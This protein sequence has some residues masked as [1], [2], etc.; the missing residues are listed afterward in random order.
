MN[1]TLCV[2]FL[3][4]LVVFFFEYETF[5]VYD[6]EDNSSAGEFVLYI[7]TFQLHYQLVWPSARINKKL[8]FLFLWGASCCVTYMYSS[9]IYI[10]CRN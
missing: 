7:I 6:T 2:F 1:N 10:R 5:S 9:Q 4:V 8:S 3:F